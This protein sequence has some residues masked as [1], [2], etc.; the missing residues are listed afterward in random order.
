MLKRTLEIWQLSPMF[1]GRYFCNFDFLKEGI[2]GMATSVGC[3]QR[4]DF[5]SHVIADL[6]QKFSGW[7]MISTH[8]CL[9]F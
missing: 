8:I 5:F 9:M 7:S 4:W 6:R 2:I 3:V 1:R